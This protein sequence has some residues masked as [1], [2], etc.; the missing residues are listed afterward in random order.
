M[1]KIL[2]LFFALFFCSSAFAEQPFKQMVFFGDSLSDNGNLYRLIK[3]P[4]SPPYYIGRFTNGTTWAE[5]LGKHFYEKYYIGIENNAYGGATTILH[6]PK[7]DSF[8]APTTLEAELFSYY[9]HS[10]RID[11]SQ[12][13]YV[14]WIGANDYLY[15]KA[16]M[17]T[18]TDNVANKIAWAINSLIGKGANKFLILNL[19][20]LATTPYAKDLQLTDRLHIIS[21]MHNKKLNDK[22][23][24]LRSQYPAVKIVT[25]DV[26]STFND[27][28]ANPK[29]YDPVLNDTIQ[30]CLSEA[31]SLKN[32]V[33]DVTGLNTNLRNAMNLP[34]LARIY[35]LEKS[36]TLCTNANEHVFW[37]FVHPTE[38]V[39]QILSDIVV[40]QLEDNGLG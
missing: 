23:N 1:K 2:S 33:P 24:E 3:F 36:Y 7:T 16:D 27:L 31:I 38:N 17:N 34:E 19:P 8:I 14:I 9:A 20:D 29:K 5:D 18:L 21:E 35:Q 26:Y 39:H 10:L 15:E 12:V 25:I 30:P 28:L 40:K 37:D 6:N 32:S 11:K 13:L 4:D 22:I